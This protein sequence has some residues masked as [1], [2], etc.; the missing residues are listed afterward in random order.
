MQSEG[1][2]MNEYVKSAVVKNWRTSF[3]TCMSGDGDVEKESAENIQYRVW[4][5]MP[6]TENRFKAPLPALPGGPLCAV[7]EAVRGAVELS[8]EIETYQA[9]IFFFLLTLLESSECG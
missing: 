6:K 1:G 3:V 8:R 5:D 9:V 2:P 4:R 7:L